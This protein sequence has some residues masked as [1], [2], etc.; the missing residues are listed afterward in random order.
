MAVVETVNAVTMAAAA[1]VAAASEEDAA[2]FTATDGTG[3]REDN[4]ACYLCLGMG[5]GFIECSTE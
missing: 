5:T 2:G 3:T 4:G 1:A